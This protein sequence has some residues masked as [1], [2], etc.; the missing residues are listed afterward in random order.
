M[1]HAGFVAVGCR[2]VSHRQNRLV[3]V[4]ST[5]CA[6][7]QFECSA[8]TAGKAWLGVLHVPCQPSQWAARFMPPCISP[9]MPNCMYCIGTGCTA[10]SR[11]HRAGGQAGQA[12]SSGSAGTCILSGSG[13]CSPRQRCA[14]SHAAGGAKRAALVGPQQRADGAEQTLHTGAAACKGGVGRA[15]AASVLC[16]QRSTALVWL[17]SETSCSFTWLADP[18]VEGSSGLRVYPRLC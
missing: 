7:A 6:G 17:T 15:E 10:S 9:T 13:S 3:R 12:G 2:G 18:L 14:Q 1:L 11:G 8:S 16:A 4:H 5:G